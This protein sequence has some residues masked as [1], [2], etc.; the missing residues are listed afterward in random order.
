MRGLSQTTLPLKVHTAR[1][2]KLVATYPHHEQRIKNIHAAHRSRIEHLDDKL[3]RWKREQARGAH[4][5]AWHAPFIRDICTC[6]D[7]DLYV[8]TG[9]LSLD[10]SYGHLDDQHTPQPIAPEQIYEHL[11]HLIERLETYPHYQLAL[12]DDTQP[13]MNP[14]KWSPYWMVS[15]GHSVILEV[16]DTTGP[17]GETDLLI[18]DKALVQAF[19]AFFLELWEHG[20]HMITDQREVVKRLRRAQEN[21]ND[22]RAR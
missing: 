2:E 12:F 15:E 6:A 16:L 22:E 10:D 19:H 7:L 1:M 17:Q 18:Q 8:R 5:W 4:K 21:I 9:V 3:D 11:N 20:E 13:S 14:L